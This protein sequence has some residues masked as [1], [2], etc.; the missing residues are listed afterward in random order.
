MTTKRGNLLSNINAL[1][2][3]LSAEDMAA[4]SAIGT[5]QGRTIN[6]SWMA[7]RWEP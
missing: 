4:I 7:G 5:R 1:G 6:P 3:E 2:F